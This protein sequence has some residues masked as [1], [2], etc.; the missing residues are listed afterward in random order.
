MTVKP[1]IKEKIARYNADLNDSIE[2]TETDDNRKIR[3][4]FK[5]LRQGTGEES[6]SKKK[7]K[8]DACKRRCKICL[9]NLTCTCVGNSKEL[10]DK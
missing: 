2:I 8:I 9:Y 7:K 5:N 4:V 3:Y 10:F 1:E 6:I